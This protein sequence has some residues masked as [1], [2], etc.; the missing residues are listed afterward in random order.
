MPTPEFTC[1]CGCPILQALNRIPNDEVH[2]V[3]DHKSDGARS[4]FIDDTKV[5]K[6]PSEMNGAEIGEQNVNCHAG[7]TRFS[8][9]R[10]ET[11]VSSI[12]GYFFDIIVT[13][14]LI[15]RF[16]PHFTKLEHVIVKTVF[17]WNFSLI[18]F[19]SI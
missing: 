15:M 7:W 16:S 19:Q 17:L 18:I 2:C 5:S 6:D 11:A 9:G 12:L 4:H 1:I 3:S 8:V 13:L 10:G 14:V